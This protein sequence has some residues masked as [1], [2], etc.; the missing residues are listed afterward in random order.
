MVT[1]WGWNPLLA[2]MCSGRLLCLYLETLKCK[3]QVLGEHVAGKL[4]VVLE[5]AEITREESHVKRLQAADIPSELGRKK[6]CTEN[7]TFEGITYYIIL[8]HHLIY[9]Y[10]RCLGFCGWILSRRKIEEVDRV[11]EMPMSLQEVLLS[12]QN[13]TINTGNMF[14]LTFSCLGKKKRMRSE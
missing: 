14:I 3:Y 7:E 1:G 11:F 9:L 2:L 10:T 5:R 8:L 12:P 4:E 13:N 6:A